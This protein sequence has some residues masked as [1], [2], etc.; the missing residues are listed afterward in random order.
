MKPYITK[1]FWGFNENALKETEEILG[2][3]NHRRF[4]ERLVILLSRCDNPKE[5]FS[6]VPKEEFVKNW[7]KV[8]NHWR[9]IAKVSDF[10][11]WWQTIYEEIARDSGVRN[12]R[13]E[14]PSVMFLR[15]G[16]LIKDKRI[17]KGWTQN[18]LALKVGMKQPDI[19]KIEEGKKNITLETLVS[20][21]STLEIK[22]I[23]LL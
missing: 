13:I 23:E 20:L 16:K 19:S 7:P 22:K 8:K 2:N 10:R 1:Y 9:K 11:D 17:E 3:P 12:K 21:S 15:I 5:L 4:P 18:E 14:R 6:I